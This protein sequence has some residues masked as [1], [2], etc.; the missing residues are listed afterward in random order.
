MSDPGDQPGQ[1]A[2][3]DFQA[4]AERAVSAYLPRQEY[5]GRL[6][7][8]A[9]RILEEATSR[10][11][12]KIHSIEARAKAPESLLR[13][14][15]QPSL[16][17]P[18]SPKYAKPLS[19]IT[20]LAAV[21]V[22]T[23]FPG[24]LSDVDSLV[25]DEF[26]VVERSD[27]GAELLED[28]RFGYQSIHYLVKLSPTRVMLPEYAPFDGSIVEIQ[29]RTIL[30]HAWAEIEHDIQYKTASVIPAE[31]R[32]RFMALAGVLEMADRE[33]QAIQDDD[34]RL[35]E[36]A[37]ES[38]RTGDLDQV[39]ITPDALKAFLDERLGPDGRISDWNYSWTARTLKGLGFSTLGQ[40]AECID[41]YDDDQLSRIVEGSRQGQT[42]RFEYMLLAGMGSH[43]GE[44][45]PWRTNNWFRTWCGESLQKMT[46]AGVACKKY[47]TSPHESSS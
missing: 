28:E 16:D 42:S 36:D 11:G 5:Y 33:F 41:G 22:I 19:Q 26:V 6:A 9:K 30:Q 14:A 38:V 35:A 31:I 21:R 40:V 7:Q 24:T 25:G 20:D 13:K 12:I 17:D 43:Y 37:R 23:F 46:D 27:K 8:A 10:R 3:F 47:D 4:H 1:D 2:Q 32:R 29:V 18:D 45:H 15:A 34:R 44:K 39:E